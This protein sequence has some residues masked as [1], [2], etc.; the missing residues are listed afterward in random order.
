MSD[1]EKSGHEPAADEGP[2][3]SAATPAPASAPTAESDPAVPPAERARPARLR[4]YRVG[5][6][7]TL[8]AAA[9]AW[10]QRDALATW[11]APLRGARVPTADAEKSARG[12]VIYTCPMHPSVRQ[13][14]PGNC[15]L[16][17]MVLTPV[18]EQEKRDGAIVLDA[19]HRER[20]GVKTAPVAVRAL[21]RE[22]RVAGQVSYDETRLSDVSLRVGGWVE[23]LH[24]A[25][26]GQQVRKGQPLLE[27]WSQELLAAEQD[28][29]TALARTG[30]QPP[31]VAATDGSSPATNTAALLVRASRQR[32]ALLGVGDAELAALESE[33]V[34][35]GKLRLSSPSGGYV[36]EKDVVVGARVEPGMRLYRIGALD[37]V[38]VE[39]RVHER[40]LSA[41]AVGQSV[42]VR[43]P[44][45]A[46]PG[47]EARVAY[48]YPDIDPSS[49]T[50]RVR[51]ELPNAGLAL[52]PGLYVDVELS[53]SLGERLV[54]PDSAVIYTGPRRLVFVDAGEGSL[55]PREVQLGVHTEGVYEV[56]GGL[57]AGELV[58]VAGNFLIAAESRIR[59]G[60]AVLQGSGHAH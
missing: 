1:T 5:I 30:S 47:S 50:A 38:W 17:G 11:L 32:L 31:G 28:Y 49:R 44:G 7:L 54:V 46:D 33:R 22:L 52:R 55:E 21:A 19:A 10:S 26:T 16:C 13:T 35:H 39:A 20:A 42:R 45:G 56:T 25:Q 6:A 2:A 37:R 41:V 14:K 8:I 12:G 34:A 58:V 53:A 24:V 3:V 51:I 36:I 40:D 27:L 18:T 4:K 59:S 60:S 29:L 57:H 43:L 23:K 15:P 9:L 48:V